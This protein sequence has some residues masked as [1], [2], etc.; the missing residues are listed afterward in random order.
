METKK[1]EDDQGLL[2]S[3][4]AVTLAQDRMNKKR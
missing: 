4:N 2:A 3:K 1:W